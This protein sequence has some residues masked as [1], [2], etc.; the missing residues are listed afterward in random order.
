MRSAGRRAGAMPLD[1]CRWLSR[2]GSLPRPGH[3]LILVGL[4]TAKVLRISWCRRHGGRHRVE[5]RPHSSRALGRESAC[6]GVSLCAAEMRLRAGVDRP[7]RAPHAGS[8][9][10]SL[11]MITC[12][13]RLEGCSGP[14]HLR[15]PRVPAS[16]RGS[17]SS[18]SS[19]SSR[20][21][22]EGPAEAALLSVRMA[23]AMLLA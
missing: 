14:L 15:R 20:S 17:P 4:T 16:P 10:R 3:G 7:V 22:G 1:G 13:L 8:V 18:P 19:G 11:T 5:P 2:S 6:L 12:K 9:D 23:A 21:G